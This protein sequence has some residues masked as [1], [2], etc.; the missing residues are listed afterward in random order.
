MYQSK[1]FKIVLID[2]DAIFWYIFLLGDHNFLLREDWSFCIDIYMAKHD[3]IQ[4]YIGED[5]S[6]SRD[7]YMYRGRLASLKRHLW[8]NTGVSVKIFLGKGW[9]F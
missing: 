6:V 1:I 5:W 3:S 8:E 2:M 9:S 4:T 7:I